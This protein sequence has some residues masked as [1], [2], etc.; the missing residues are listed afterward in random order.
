MAK[1]RNKPAP[2]GIAYAD[3]RYDI[4]AIGSSAGGLNALTQA[5]R[6]IP[7]NFPS[8]IVVVQ[9]LAPRHKSMMPELLAR[10]LH[11]RAK[12]AEHGE[13]ILPGW[14]YVAP[15]DEHLLVG[16][17]KLQLLHSQLVHFSRPS[18]D[19]LFESVA[20]TYGSRSVGL[21][22]SGSGLDGASGMAA[23][24]ESGGVT[25][26]QNDAE[27][28]ALPQAALET[29]SVDLQVPLHKIAQTLLKLCCGNHQA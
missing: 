6:S 12:Q 23:I 24:K 13:I 14:V 9:H 28:K 21:I 25:I 16:P 4:V 2:R 1:A 29:H 27:F 19:L 8:S 22:L 3:R 5:L 17:G 11:L 15:P 7:A 26:V 20:G 10:S 18:I